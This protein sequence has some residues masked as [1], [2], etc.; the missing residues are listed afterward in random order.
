[1]TESVAVSIVGGTCSGFI[2]TILFQPL[3]LLKTRMQMKHVSSFRGVRALLSSK[4]LQD[5]AIVKAW[6][7]GLQ[8]SLYRTIPGVA[9]YFVTLSQL[10]KHYG[11]DLGPMSAVL[12]GALARTITVLCTQP[13]TLVKTRYESGKFGYKSVMGAVKEILL[14]DRLAGLYRGF[15]ATILR[16]AP[17]SGLYLAS[18]TQLKTKAFHG[19][20]SV[21]STTVS[22]LTAGCAASLMTHPADVVKTRI[23]TSTTPAT[24]GQITAALFREG[25]IP[26]FYSGFV[27]RVVRRT[28][29][30]CTAWL[31]YEEV[32]KR[33]YLIQ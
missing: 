26:A 3:D 10:R 12:I 23:Q 14:R 22:G 7:V 24:V 18:Y 15:F 16:D 20:D 21:A 2:C 1:M 32:K 28:L 17:F 27:P 33:S 30:S 25:G 9:C 4:A 11:E 29:V 6:W 19:S 31:I 8:P 5:G 13:L